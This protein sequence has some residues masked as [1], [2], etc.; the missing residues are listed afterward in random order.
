MT[1]RHVLEDDG[2]RPDEK[3][4]EEPEIAEVAVAAKCRRLRAESAPVGQRIMELTVFES[5]P[6]YRQSMRRTRS[7]PKDNRRRDRAQ[8]AGVDHAG[9]GPLTA[10]SPGRRS[11]VPALCQAERAT[12][13]VQGVGPATRTSC[14]P[15]GSALRAR[16][17]VNGFAY[18]LMSPSYVPRLSRAAWS[19]DPSVLPA[20]EWPAR[21]SG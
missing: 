15:P 3:R 17:A 13:S 11:P 8:D 4:A 12:R 16:S 5:K 6:G 1:Q 21:S 2:G 19:R 10:R 7:F 20:F 9:A 14:S 18:F